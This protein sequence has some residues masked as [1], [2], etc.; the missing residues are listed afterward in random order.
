VAAP[1]RHRRNRGGGARHPRSPGGA[2]DRIIV[3]EVVG[4]HG[5]AGAVR[6]APATDFPD[7]LLD[8]ADVVLVSAG[9]ARPVRVERSSRSGRVVLMKF[10]GTGTR[11]AAEALR[12]ATVEIPARDAA[13]LPPGQFY[14]FQVIGLEVRTPEGKAIGRVVDILRTGSNDVYVVRPPEGGEIL[15]PALDSVVLRIDIGAGELV[16]RLPEWTP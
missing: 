1:A 7:R 3:G 2:D 13:P 12:G 8:L 4:A 15:L 16:A 14:T 9:A 6:V 11:G 5:V 10:Q